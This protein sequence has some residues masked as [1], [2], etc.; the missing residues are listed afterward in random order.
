MKKELHI[1]CLLVVA[2]LFAIG[3][4]FSFAKAKKG[5]LRVSGDNTWTVFIGGEKVAE[6][7]DW[8]RPTVSEFQL[9]DGFAVIAVYIH[10]AE[11]GGAGSGGFLADIILDDGTYIGTSD[12]KGDKKD[13]WLG[14]KSDGGKLLNDRKDGWEKVNFTDEKWTEPQEYEQFGGGIWGFGAATMKQI[15]HDPDCTAHWI[16]HG[17]NNV[18]DDVYFRYTIGTF[19]V[20][21]VEKLTTAWG[22]IKSSR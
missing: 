14:W 21:S 15:L 10:D 12:Y 2:F 6:G 8:Q 16:W 11:P 9:K 1:L 4:S 17:P 5:T 22:Q 18:Q 19:A 7:A 13:T 20:A 3:V